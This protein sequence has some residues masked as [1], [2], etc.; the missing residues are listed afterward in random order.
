MVSFIIIIV[1][2]CLFVLLLCS[3]LWRRDRWHLSKAVMNI[4]IFRGND[5]TTAGTVSIT[6][7]SPHRKLNNRARPPDNKM[8]CFSLKSFQEPLFGMSPSEP[9]RLQKTTYII[10][11]RWTR[12]KEPPWKTSLHV[13]LA[14]SLSSA[15]HLRKFYVQ[16]I[17][18]FIPSG[19]FCSFICPIHPATHSNTGILKE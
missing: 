6:C 17:S 1:V 8:S 19:T 16:I 3:G 9:E 12:P 7:S 13:C 2:V 15:V 14:S 5:E 10:P 11:L 4:T 18:Q